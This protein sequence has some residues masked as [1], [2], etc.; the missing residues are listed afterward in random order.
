M[1]LLLASLLLLATIIAGVVVVRKTLKSKDA[2]PPNP[3]AEV[4]IKNIRPD[5]KAGSSNP[6]FDPTATQLYL[7]PPP[8]T[9]NADQQKR[10]GTVISGARLVGLSGSQKGTSVP[11]SAEGVTIGRATSCNVVLT[12]ARV[13]GNHAWVGLVNGKAVLRDLKS[14]NGTFLNANTKTSVTEIELCSGD[15]IFFG[16]HQGD[17]FKFVAE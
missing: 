11:L 15:T 13:S 1:L 17:Q 14:T 8:A 4:E 2:P 12:D 9:A 10:Q 6:A 3:A 16:G 7:R 5:E